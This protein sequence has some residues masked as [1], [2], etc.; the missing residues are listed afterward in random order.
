MNINERIHW[1][2]KA[3]C[4]LKGKNIKD[5]EKELGRSTGYLSRKTTIIDVKMLLKLSEIFD[6]PTDEILHGD[7]NH[8]VVLKE[9]VETL[10]S[11][12]LNAKQYFNEDAI[13]NVI[14]PLIEQGEA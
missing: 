11:A 7:F 6:V 5:I 3:L 14:T 8:E 13:M 9:T 4:K 12:V 2:V 10:K 1:N